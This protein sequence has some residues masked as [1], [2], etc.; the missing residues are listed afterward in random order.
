MIGFRGDRALLDGLAGRMVGRCRRRWVVRAR[1]V[2]ALVVLMPV[3]AIVIML[4]RRWS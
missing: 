2:E 3:I 1:I 4:G